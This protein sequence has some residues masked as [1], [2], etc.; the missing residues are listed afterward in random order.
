MKK[1][2]KV[3]DNIIKDVRNVF[4]LQKDGNGTTIKKKKRRRLL[5]INKNKEE[6]NKEEDYYKQVREGSFWSDNYIEYESD[7][8]RNKTLS[9]EEY[10]NK[11]KPYL[12]DII[13]LIHGKF[14]E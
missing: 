14:K 5:I 10:F 4:R 13:N 6:D 7:G 11:I 12:N 3:E 8:D 2:K 9:I 1:I